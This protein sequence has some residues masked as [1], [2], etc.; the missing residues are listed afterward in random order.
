M[1]EKENEKKQRAEKIGNYAKKV[2]EMYWPKASVKKQ[3]ELE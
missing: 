3:I 1:E 2:K